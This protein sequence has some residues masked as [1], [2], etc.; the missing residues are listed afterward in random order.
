[1]GCGQTA[2]KARTHFLKLGVEQ[3]D[4]IPSG[5]RTY[6]MPGPEQGVVNCPCGTKLRLRWTWSIGSA[7]Y[8]VRCPDCDAEHRL[9]ATSPIE[10][11][12]LDSQGNWEYVTTIG[13][14]ADVTAGESKR[15]AGKKVGDQ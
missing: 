7:I 5:L 6:L 12:R 3:K 15:T 8:P 10:V 14:R 2:R 4:A 9:H 13:S 11:Y 1:M